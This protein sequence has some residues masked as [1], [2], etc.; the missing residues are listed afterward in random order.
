MVH[1]FLQNGN[2]KSLDQGGA[3]KKDDIM[4]NQQ[5]AMMMLNNPELA[6]SIHEQISDTTTN[7]N[8]LPS[9]AN[10][11]DRADE[12][13]FYLESQHLRDSLRDSL[14]DPAKVFKAAKAVQKA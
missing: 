4:R 3:I 11:N 10:K 13:T 7:S 1:S 8:W 5:L 12:D 2:Y 14:A 6:S 9:I